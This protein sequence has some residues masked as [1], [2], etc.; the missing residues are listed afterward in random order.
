[1]FELLLPDSEQIRCDGIS[2]GEED[3]QIFMELAANTPDSACPLCNKKSR[4]VHSRY[5]R[6]L[7]DLPWADVPSRFR[8][9]FAVSS[10]QTKTVPE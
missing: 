10:A 1:M 5:R 6:H 8:F 2:V 3:R 9:R 4:K 7:A